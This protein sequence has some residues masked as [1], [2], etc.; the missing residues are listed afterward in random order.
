MQPDAYQGPE[1]RNFT[2]LTYARGQRPKLTLGRYVFEILELSEQGLRIFCDRQN[3]FKGPVRG[4]IQFPGGDRLEV[5]GRII[6]EILW[7]EKYKIGVSLITAPIPS[8]I[9]REEIKRI[10][11]VNGVQDPDR[12]TEGA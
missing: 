9:I 7:E 4:V 6:W 2:R 1:R 12:A 3:K 11:N 10:R 8:R 5:E